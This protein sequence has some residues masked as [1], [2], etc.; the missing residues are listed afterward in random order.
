MATQNFTQEVDDGIV[1]W[2]AYDFA[3]IR[4]RDAIFL[5]Q[6]WKPAAVNVSQRII[7]S[8]FLPTRGATP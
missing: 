4:V 6:N 5:E 3:H 7:T 8:Y 1:W 2:S